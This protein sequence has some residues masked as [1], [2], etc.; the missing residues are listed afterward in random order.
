MKRGAKRSGQYR[1]PTKRGGNELSIGV[2]PIVAEI[3]K[4]EKLDERRK[5][6]KRQRKTAENS[7]QV[8]GKNQR[9]PPSD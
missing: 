7:S 5:G 3:D 6:R 1:Y 4:K 8:K 9:R 2:P